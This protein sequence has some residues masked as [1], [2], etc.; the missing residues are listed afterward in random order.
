MNHTIRITIEQSSDDFYWAYAENV[1]ALTGAGATETEARENILECIEL[2]K[3]ENN[4]PA[5]LDDNYTLLY[6]FERI[7][8]EE[9]VLAQ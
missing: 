4:H 9:E 3:K 7:T 5:V 2:L 6:E 8:N 1:P